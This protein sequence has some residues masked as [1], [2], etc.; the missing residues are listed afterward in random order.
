MLG[1]VPASPAILKHA[2]PVL[3]CRDLVYDYPTR[4]L[5]S[6][7]YPALDRISLR[8]ARGETLGILGES[9]CGK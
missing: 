7:P 2:P 6:R 8:I 1:T 4:R 5:L 3:E 9:G